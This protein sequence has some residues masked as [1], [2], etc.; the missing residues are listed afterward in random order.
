M[1][2][3]SIS[4]SELAELTHATQVEKFNFCTCED[5]EGQENPYKDCPMT[6]DQAKKI[7][8][9]QPTWALK[10]MVKALQMLPWRNTTEDEQR[11]LAAKVVLKERNKK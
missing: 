4:W 6:I 2:Q 10:N 3:E 7:V 5:N 8:G 9:N 1:S 11:L